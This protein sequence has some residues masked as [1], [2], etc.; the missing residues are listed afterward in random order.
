MASEANMVAR[1]L[2]FRGR[3]GLNGVFQSEEIIKLAFKLENHRKEPNFPTE[4]ENSIE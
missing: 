1:E 4:D 3:R 2:F